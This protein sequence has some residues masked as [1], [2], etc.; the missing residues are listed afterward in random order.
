MGGERNVM[1]W[2]AVG[3]SIM[4]IHTGSYS[5]DSSWTCDGKPVD[6]GP[7]RSEDIHRRSLMAA[8]PPCN[9]ECAS[10]TSLQWWG[11]QNKMGCCFG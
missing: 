9:S 8:L 1:G 7:C 6:T 10:L 2:E 5:P 4:K 3:G 11:G